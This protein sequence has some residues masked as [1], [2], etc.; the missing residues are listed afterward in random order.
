MPRKPKPVTAI[1]I[2]HTTELAPAIPVMTPDGTVVGVQIGD[3]F[4]PLQPTETRPALM[5]EHEIDEITADVL[6]TGRQAL[7]GLQQLR[8]MGQLARDIDY[9][10]Q[11]LGQPRKAV[12]NLRDNRDHNRARDETIR[13]YREGIRAVGQQL[14]ELQADR[15]RYVREAHPEAADLMRER[16]RL[17]VVRERLELEL[18]FSESERNRV[19]ELTMLDRTHA[20]AQ[21]MALLEAGRQ[22]PDLMRELEELQKKNPTLAVATTLKLMETTLASYQAMVAATDKAA[23]AQMAEVL[24]PMMMHV[25]QSAMG[26]IK[27]AAA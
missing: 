19:Q 6:H 7:A 20:H 27:K 13:E 3:Q 21:Y 25:I 11:F 23:Q 22:L 16:Q 10:D 18:P 2:A 15:V 26:E 14:T 17:P 1:P 12:S 4:V 5:P 8:I 9:S 24:K